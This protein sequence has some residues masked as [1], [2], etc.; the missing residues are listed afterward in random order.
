MKKLGEIVVPEGPCYVK[1][2]MALLEWLKE[3]KKRNQEGDINVIKF[4]EHFA[5]VKDGN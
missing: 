2:R 3:Y 4:L 5:E 1:T